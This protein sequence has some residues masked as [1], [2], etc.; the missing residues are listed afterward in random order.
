MRLVEE[1]KPISEFDTGAL[2]GSDRAYVIEADTPENVRKRNELHFVAH[3]DIFIPAG[4][5][6]YTVN[7]R[8]GKNF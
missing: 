2:S 1:A 3:A 6:P 7:E 8:I 5:R 4:G